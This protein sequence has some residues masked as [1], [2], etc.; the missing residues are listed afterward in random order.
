MDNLT[1]SLRLLF[2]LDINGLTNAII[3]LLVIV[4]IFFQASRLKHKKNR[5]YLL[6][7]Q[8]ELE[9]RI[10]YR[11]AKLHTLNGQLYQEITKH[12]TTEAL[13][14]DTQNYLTSIINSMPS[15]LIGVTA[16][17]FITHWNLAA[18]EA[19]DISADIA[20]G[21]SLL[22]VYPSIPVTLTNIQETIDTG[23]ARLTENVQQSYG[24]Q[25]QHIDLNIYPLVRD[26]SS[27]FSSQQV[28]KE[29]TGAVIRLDNV[30]LRVQMENMMIQ[31]EKMMSLGEL[32]AGMAHEI[33]NPLSAMVNAVQ[34]IQ[35]RTAVD[36]PA[37]L[38]AARKYHVE[39]EQVY[40]YLNE[41]SIFKF[42]DSIREAGDRAASIVNN[43][44][45]FSRSNS[46]SH[47]LVDITKLTEH[48]LELANNSFQLKTPN[49]IEKVTI[50]Q[51]FEANLPL[52][53]CSAPELQQVV[54]N[55]LRNACQ[56]FSHSNSNINTTP[57]I[58]LRLHQWQNNIC[59]EVED[60]GQGMTED[61]RKHIF[62]PFYTTKELGQGTGLG[63]SVTYFIV[64]E[65]HNGTI[66]VESALGQG[67]NFIINLPMHSGSEC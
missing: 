34:N 25:C 32:A 19:T 55:L 21:K 38:E 27:P 48:S 2:S 57:T 45:E 66:E 11:T 54:L 36:F 22:E 67:T 35:R 14:S 53:K 47:E 63:L 56:A 43:M 9:Q 6:I 23:I 46:R 44:L 41:R 3:S 24:N 16:D 40:N 64:T 59:V 61:V 37:N 65:H 49:G 31:N 1:D 58:T 52:V 18:Q 12:Q 30:T 26:G 33:N 13:L 29:L 15:I 51:E 28:T 20:L 60:N 50:N 62:E 5:K 7:T 8:K 42:L 10:E 4:I 17:G 39:I